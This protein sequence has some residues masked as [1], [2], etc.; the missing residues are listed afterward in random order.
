M[1]KMLKSWDYWKPI[2]ITVGTVGGSVTITL[3]IMISLFVYFS[4]KIILC[5]LLAIFILGSFIFI[6]REIIEELHRIGKKN[7]QKQDARAR[8]NF[9]NLTGQELYD[10]KE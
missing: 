5:S 9:K 8:K 4:I 1:N 6:I 3:A 2:L 7:F 10:N